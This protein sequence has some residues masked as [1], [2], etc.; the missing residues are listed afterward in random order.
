MTG[1]TC[2]LKSTVDLEELIAHTVAAAVIMIVK[3]ISPFLDGFSVMQSGLREIQDSGAPLILHKNAIKEKAH[4]VRKHIFS[5]IKLRVQLHFGHLIIMI[6]Q[7][8]HIEGM[9]EMTPVFAPPDIQTRK[10]AG[11]R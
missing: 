3:R 7:L 11:L 4:S 5:I 10:I 2:V 1:F 9:L 8:M 6:L